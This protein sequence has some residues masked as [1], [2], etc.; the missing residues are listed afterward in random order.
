MADLEMWE[1]LPSPSASRDELLAHVDRRVRQLIKDEV[2]KRR[3]VSGMTIGAVMTGLFG[4][5]GWW[6]WDS[7]GAWRWFEVPIVF[8]L[9]VGVVG[10]FTS[11]RR[12]VRDE[13]GNVVKSQPAPPV[14]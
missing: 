5:L 8:L 12:S 3:D 7:G 6:A 13:K 2:E 10:F 11:L 9:I 4:W 1:K 14:L